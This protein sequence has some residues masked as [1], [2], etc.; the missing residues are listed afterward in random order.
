MLGFVNKSPEHLAALA[1][2][3]AWTRERF[4]LSEDETILVA[5]IAC[6]LPGCPPLETVVV[7]WTEP[8]ARH[9]FKVFKPVA[10]VDVGDLPP[11]WMKPAI[12]VDADAGFYCC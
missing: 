11:A 12:V 10:Q 2:V 9:Q 4:R 1:R 3:K 5:E 7:F 8:N 6:R